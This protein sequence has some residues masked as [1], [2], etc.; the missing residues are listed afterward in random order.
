MR[1]GLNYALK[2]SK[3]DKT[4]WTAHAQQEEVKAF[5]SKTN[6]GFTVSFRAQEWPSKHVCVFQNYT[7]KPSTTLDIIEK[8]V[9]WKYRCHWVEAFRRYTVVQ[10]QPRCCIIFLSWIFCGKCSIRVSYISTSYIGF[11]LLF[12]F[13]VFRL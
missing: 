10:S 2:Y 9:A 5:H 7:R 8:S 4:P 11:L 3:W 13:Y 12:G 1:C 6:S